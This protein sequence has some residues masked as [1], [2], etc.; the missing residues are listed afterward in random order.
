MTRVNLPLSQMTL[1]QKLDLMEMLW[2]DLS[3]NE[4]TLDSP[5]WH[6]AVLKEREEA[7]NAGKVKIS[8]WD[9]AKK[10]IRKNVL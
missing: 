5:A 9:E 3:Q 8:D 1:A 7:L 2:D 4:Q 6:E 10:R